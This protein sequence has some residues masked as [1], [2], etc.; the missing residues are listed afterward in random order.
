M[1][2]TVSIIV[3]VWNHW[4]DVTKSFICNLMEK[5]RGVEF[6]L[7]IVNNGSSDETKKFLPGIIRKFDNVAAINLPT[8]L[9]FGGGNNV[10]FKKAKGKFICFLNN[11][12]VVKNENWLSELVKLASENINALYGHQL[13]TWNDWTRFRLHNYSYINGYCIFAAK[14]LFEDLIE[15]E[16]LFDE[17]FGKAYFE[18]VDL[19]VRAVNKGY[20]L[21]EVKDL[22]IFHLQSKSSDQIDIS[23]QTLIAKRHYLNKMMI[24]HLDLLKKKRIVFFLRS[25]YPFN[26]GDW[27]G[28]GVG[29]AEASLI[30]L[31]RSFAKAGWRTEIYNN[32]RKIGTFN[33]VEYHNIFEFNP[34]IYCDVFVLFRQPESFIEYVNAVMKIFWSCD[35]YTTGNW[36]KDTIP[37]V[38]KV[39]TISPYHKNYVDMVYGPIKHKIE[40]VEL[41][42]NIKDYEKKLEKVP[43]KLIYC[44]VPGRGL[45]YLSYLFP[46]IKD[47]IPNATLYITSD[48]RL[49]GVESPQ[50]GDYRASLGNIPGVHFLGKI[51][52]K[53]LVYHQKTAE[54]MA[55]PCDYEECFCVSAMECIAAGAIPVTTDVGAMKSTVSDS[56]IVLSN[57]PS[58]P[59]YDKNFIASAVNLLTDRESAEKLREDGWKRV[60]EKYD[61]DKVLNKWLKIIN[62]FIKSKEGDFMVFCDVCQKKVS[63]SYILAKHKAKYHNEVATITP[64]VTTNYNPTQLLK[65]NVAI[66]VNIN[67]KKFEGKEVEVPYDMVSAVM[68]IVRTAYGPQAIAV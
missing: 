24:H 44:S 28:K 12:V 45:K 61:W 34:A 30:L 67:G 11:D 52:R 66:E 31:A 65:F 37:Y 17:Y 23:H 62:D 48:Y 53:E 26:D 51:P 6:E 16:M 40:M 35:Q 19:S 13:V 55:Y 21:F 3:C 46:R 43:G 42:I 1:K 25:S 50:N 8:N 59:S 56:G 41:G 27:E 14:T 15:D 5:T 4:N 38:D 63:N 9:G 39:I 7:I 20:E 29:G 18:D 33:G 47:K 54:V 68:E 57:I 58:Y 10:G 36:K 32:T 22:G 49:W 2:V 64:A 60:V